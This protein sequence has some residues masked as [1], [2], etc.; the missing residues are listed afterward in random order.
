MSAQ[1]FALSQHATPFG[2]RSAAHEESLLT[3]V[4]STLVGRFRD[5][6]AEVLRSRLQGGVLT[7]EGEA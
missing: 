5:D 6:L 4:G 2:L 7:S 3:A 1:R